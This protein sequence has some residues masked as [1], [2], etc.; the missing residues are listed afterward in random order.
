MMGNV[1][2][3]GSSYSPPTCALARRAFVSIVPPRLGVIERGLAR[4]IARQARFPIH[5]AAV[6]P[7]TTLLTYC[8][9]ALL[10]DSPNR[11]GVMAAI[12]AYALR[13]GLSF[14]HLVKFVRQPFYFD[15]RVLSRPS[16]LRLRFADVHHV[17]YHLE[18]VFSV[19]FGTVAIRHCNGAVALWS[20]PYRAFCDVLLQLFVQPFT[21][22][23]EGQAL[24]NLASNCF[25]FIHH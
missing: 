2:L 17:T 10:I 7:F 25:D 14:L 24:V 4:A 5:L 15:R 20:K 8:V 3:L 13:S 22:L 9:T 12:S 18:D 19:G 21:Q 23:V 6:N 11:R 1:L 16:A